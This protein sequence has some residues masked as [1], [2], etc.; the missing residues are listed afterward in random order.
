MK[1]L[2][3][4]GEDEDERGARERVGRWTPERVRRV[5]LTLIDRPAPLFDIEAAASCNLSCR[6]CPRGALTRPQR[7]MTPE[8]FAAVERFLP[9]D[10][11]VMFAGL[12]EPLSNP[13]LP[14]YLARLKRR[15]VSSCVITNGVLM[16]PPRLMA[17]IDAGIDQVQVSIHAIDPA[18]FRRL[19]PDI[20]IDRLMA[21]LRALAELRP[22]GLRVRLN[23]VAGPENGG[24]L[25]GV[26]ALARDLG[27]ELFVRREH[28]R[29]GHLRGGDGLVDGCGIFASVTFVTAQGDVLSCVNDVAGR[30]CV[31]NVRGVRWGDVI[32]WKRRTVS[33][34]DGFPVCA[35]CDDGYRWVLLDEGDL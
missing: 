1:E 32:A 22:P 17:L 31:G 21:N 26:A 4:N 2:G 29:G 8:T 15:G 28:N 27:V 23:F 25:A 20:E 6:F 35:E 33:S 3:G 11:V 16:T 7:I 19:V 34:G 12:G 24:E 18:V 14:E 13:H 9:A 5:S 30:S 10:A